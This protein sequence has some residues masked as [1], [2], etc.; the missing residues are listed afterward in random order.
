MIINAAAVVAAAAVHTTTSIT[1]AIAAIV[2]LVSF[3]N[4]AHG[5]FGFVVAPFIAIVTMHFH[6][7]FIVPPASNNVALYGMR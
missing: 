7:N 4:Q 5:S 6:I 3:R 2:V 1:T